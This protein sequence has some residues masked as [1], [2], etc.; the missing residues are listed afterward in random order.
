MILLISAINQRLIEAG[1]R[2]SV[3]IIV[4]TGQISSSHH[5][6]CALGFGAAAVYPLS[7]LLRAQEKFS[8]NPEKAYKNFT[9]A[10]E[11]ALMKTMGKVGLCTVESYSGG[12]FFEPNF[13]DTSDPILNKYFPN[14]DSPVGGVGFS[15]ISLSMAELA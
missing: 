13:L 2:F 5:I 10:S 14:M 11:K 4:Q 9:K 15:D 1:L 7:V 3:S 12:E 8:N 6:A